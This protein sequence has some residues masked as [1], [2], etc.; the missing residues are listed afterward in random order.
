MPDGRFHQDFIRL[1]PPRQHS[2]LLQGDEVWPDAEEA[3][4]MKWTWDI[5]PQLQTIFRRFLQ[6]DDNLEEGFANRQRADFIT[7]TLAN[8]AKL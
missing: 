5:L 7:R 4:R 3:E 6:S 8:L 2:W 1:I